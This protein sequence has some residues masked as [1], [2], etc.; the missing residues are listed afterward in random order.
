MKQ[1][2]GD[3]GRAVPGKPHTAV[4]VVHV[5]MDSATQRVNRAGPEHLVGAVAAK[6]DP[7]QGIAFGGRRGGVVGIGT[8]PDIGLDMPL[9]KT[10]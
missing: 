1:A 7:V 8:Q 6:E 10:L 3:R 9:A 4:A 2:R 5:D